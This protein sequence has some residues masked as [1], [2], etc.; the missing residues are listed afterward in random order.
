MH[1]LEVIVARNARAVEAYYARLSKALEEVPQADTK[2]DVHPPI[3][4][5]TEPWCLWDLGD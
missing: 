3:I 1:C 2:P 5:P 4:F